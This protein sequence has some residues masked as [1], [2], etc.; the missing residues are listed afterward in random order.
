MQSSQIW[1]K[2]FNCMFWCM[3]GEPLLLKGL[4]NIKLWGQ[5]RKQGRE[6]GV[7]W[8]SDVDIHQEE[9]IPCFPSM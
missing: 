3:G 7:P 9:E 1:V 8:S 5:K 6:S 4:V 2:A